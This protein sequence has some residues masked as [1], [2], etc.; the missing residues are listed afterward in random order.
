M[1]CN[2]GLPVTTALNNLT[3]DLKGKYYPLGSMSEVI[4]DWSFL[5]CSV[6]KQ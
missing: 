3:G 6:L 1:A 2:D 5:M 4:C